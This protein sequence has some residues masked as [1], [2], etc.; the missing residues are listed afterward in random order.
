MTRLQ[1]QEGDLRLETANLQI[2]IGLVALRISLAEILELR[3][4]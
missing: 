3:E 2:E 4:A 1:Q